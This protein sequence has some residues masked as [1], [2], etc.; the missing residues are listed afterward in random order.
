M[1][2]RVERDPVTVGNLEKIWID[3]ILTAYQIH[4]VF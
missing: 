1:G 2:G 4:R 3:V